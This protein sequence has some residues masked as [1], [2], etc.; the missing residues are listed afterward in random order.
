V[1]PGWLLV[2]HMHLLLM[3]RT[4]HWSLV[5]TTASGNLIIHLRLLLVTPETQTNYKGLAEIGITP[6][7]MARER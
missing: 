6:L 4:E 1:V 7:I 3:C 5:S 2:R